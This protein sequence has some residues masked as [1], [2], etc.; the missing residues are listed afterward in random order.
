MNALTSGIL[1]SARLP[2]A[3]E[4]DL[5][6]V[7]IAVRGAPDPA[8]IRMARIVNTTS[9]GT[10]WVTASVRQ[11]L[12]SR[13]GLAVDDITLPLEFSESGRLLPMRESTV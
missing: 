6:A 5:E 9:L 11:E 4:N 1:R 10:F 8:R 7:Q 13:D 2:L 12:A 3:V